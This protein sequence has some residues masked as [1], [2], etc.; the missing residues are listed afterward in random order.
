MAKSILIVEDS[1]SVRC[2]LSSVLTQYGYTVVEAV[3]GRDGLI[4][5][6][7]F[8]ADLIIT[9]LHM[10]GLDG[11]G[12]IHEVRRNDAYRFLPIIILTTDNQNSMRKEAVTA[13]ATAW[14]AKPF[15]P[16]E[17][18]GVIRKFTN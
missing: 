6:E 11:I 4:K 9:D 5:L 10:P 15:T 18:L 3:D 13:G 7:D 8:G 2:L 17:I 12:L 14:V 16:A 1:S